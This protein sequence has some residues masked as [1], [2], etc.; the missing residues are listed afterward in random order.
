MK[1]NI[2]NKEKECNNNMSEINSTEKNTRDLGE[3]CNKKLINKE[4]SVLEN[5]EKCKQ[6]QQLREQI[7]VVSR[8]IL[9]LYICLSIAI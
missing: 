9:W 1:E 5:E 6:H 7:E 4:K 8:N 2:K 3:D